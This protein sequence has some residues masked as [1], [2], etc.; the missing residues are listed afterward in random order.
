M[1]AEAGARLGRG[2]ILAV[3]AFAY[4]VAFPEDVSAILTPVE[5]VLGLTNAVSP[6]LY[7]LLGAGVIAR[8]LT[9]CFGRS[10]E[11]RSP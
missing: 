9:Q 6:W 4:F 11:I 2:T 1:S 5:G 3:V 10:P 7:V 8:A